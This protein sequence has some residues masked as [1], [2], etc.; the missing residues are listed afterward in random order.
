VKLLFDQNI[1]FRVANK[2][3]AHFPGCEQVRELKLENKTDREIWNFAKSE[4][5]TIVTFDA[6]FYDSATLFGH[7][8]KVIWL[9]MDN[10]SLAIEIC[11]FGLRSNPYEFTLLN[12]KAYSLAIENKV[13][14]A[15]KTFSQIDS[16]TLN[17]KD[18][19][20]YTATM[21]LISYRNGA[22]EQGGSLYEQAEQLAKKQK[23]E[24]TAFRVRIYKAK[25]EILCGCNAVDKH[26]AFS[27]LMAD[28][29]KFKQPDIVRTMKNLEKKLNI[30]N[31]NQLNN[32]I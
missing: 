18:K 23:D 3:Q 32:T 16:N 27:R 21:G 15:E 1:S 9:R 6:D 5:Y 10:N 24:R 20:A 31:D 8:P 14:E 28:L 7:P 17:D 26:T 13:E 19:I 12:N 11:N 25:A 30:Q 29:E 22:E 4:N 2:L